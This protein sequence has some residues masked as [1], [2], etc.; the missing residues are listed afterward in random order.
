MPRRFLQ[1]PSLTRLSPRLECLRLLLPQLLVMVIHN[2]NKN[3]KTNIR[4]EQNSFVL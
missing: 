3:V 2:S 1:I 4:M